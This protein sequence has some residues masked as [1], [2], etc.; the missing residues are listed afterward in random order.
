MAGG[1]RKRERRHKGLYLTPYILKMEHEVSVKQQFPNGIT[2]VMSH[3]DHMTS[4]HILA[5][6]LLDSTYKDQ[7]LH[8]HVY[9]PGLSGK[10]GKHSARK[11]SEVRENRHLQTTALT[12]L[13]VG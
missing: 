11:R 7:F 6:I 9:K 1:R 13:H 8:V 5:A 10:E 2:A 12:V 4:K 3:V